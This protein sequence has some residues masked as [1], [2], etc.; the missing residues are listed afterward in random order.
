MPEVSTSG[1]RRIG[2]LPGVSSIIATS[3][4]GTSSIN[5]QFEL[6]E[7]RC[8][9]CDVQTG[10]QYGARR[11]CPKISASARRSRRQPRGPLLMTI[12]V[13]FGHARCRGRWTPRRNYLTRKS[14]RVTGS[15]SSI[16]TAGRSRAVSVQRTRAGLTSLGV[17][18]E[19]LRGSS[20]GVPHST[21]K[22]TST[23]RDEPDLDTRSARTRRRLRT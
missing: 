5:V 8:G 10:H 2:D 15:G 9:R 11:T 3:S 13:I 6:S 1:S 18:L 17:S 12:A 23:A 16:T 20:S 19:E 21:A 7:S 22:G 4:L 14:R